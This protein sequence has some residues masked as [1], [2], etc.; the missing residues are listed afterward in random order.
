[1]VV[2]RQVYGVVMGSPTVPWALVISTV[3]VVPGGRSARGVKTADMNW[4]ARLL[5]PACAHA[6][7][8]ADCDIRLNEASRHSRDTPVR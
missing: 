7:L 1:M 4:G 6:F 8:P 3:N 2:K 5:A